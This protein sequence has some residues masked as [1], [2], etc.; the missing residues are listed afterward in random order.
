[1]NNEYKPILI[2]NGNE[3]HLREDGELTCGGCGYIFDSKSTEYFFNNIEIKPD[4]ISGETKVY[5]APLCCERCGREFEKVHFS[6]IGKTMFIDSAIASASNFKKRYITKYGELILPEE[7]R[8]AELV[9]SLDPSRR[10]KMSYI[11][12]VA[13]M[14]YSSGIKADDLKMLIDRH[15]CML[16][17][18]GTI[19]DASLYEDINRVSRNAICHYANQFDKIVTAMDEMKKGD[20]VLGDFVFMGGD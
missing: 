4:C 18:G 8:Y 15:G 20:F 14:L 11:E 1:M 13:Y 5:S 2:C 19:I 3:K 16:Y 7:H 6:E 10:I 17:N 9:P 12:S